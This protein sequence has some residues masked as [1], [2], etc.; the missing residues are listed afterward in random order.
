M[1]D[2]TPRKDAV[3]S[4]E[5]SQRVVDR[6]DLRGSSLNQLSPE[7]HDL[8]ASYLGRQGQGG[9]ILNPAGEAV[10]LTSKQSSVLERELKT[11]HRAAQYANQA[12]N[13]DVADELIGKIAALSGAVERMLGTPTMVDLRNA[14]LADPAAPGSRLHLARLGSYS[15]IM[16]DKA[17]RDTLINMGAGYSHTSAE[18]QLLGEL[19]VARGLKATGADLTDAQR[20]R[21]IGAREDTQKRIEE[22]AKRYENEKDGFKKIEISNEMAAQSVIFSQ[23]NKIIGE[24]TKE[25]KT[26]LEKMVGFTT[27]LAGI[28]SLSSMASRV[29]LQ[30]P[31]TYGTAPALGALGQQGEIASVVSQGLMAVEQY[32]LARSQEVFGIGASAMGVG[33]SMMLNRGLG[34]G[35][36]GFGGALGVAGGLVASSGL[37]LLGMGDWGVDFMKATGMAKSDDEIFGVTLAQQLL[38][39]QRLMSNF[40]GGRTGMLAVGGN[41]LGYYFNED[42]TRKMAEGDLIGEDGSIQRVVTGNR[43]LDEIFNN[44]LSLLSLVDPDTMSQTISSAA[45]SLTGSSGIGLTDAAVLAERTGGAFGIGSDAA[46]GMLEMLQSAGVNDPTRSLHMAIGGGADA[47]GNINTFTVGNITQSIIAATQSLK[48]QNIAR[49][50]DEL[51]KEVTGFRQQIVRGGSPLG[52]MLETNP[53]LFNKVMQDV[54]SSVKQSLHDPG[55]LALDLSLGSSLKDVVEGRTDVL[56]RRIQFFSDSPMLEGIDFSDMDEVFGNQHAV[57][58]LLRMRELTGIQDLQVLGSLVQTV[59]DPSSQMTP[60][61][62][63]ALVQGGE[64]A[65]DDRVLEIYEST[66]G[67]TEALLN[68]QVTALTASMQGVMQ[69]NI[70]LNEMVM[71]YISNSDLITASSAAIDKIMG[72]LEGIMKTGGEGGD[73]DPGLKYDPDM[74][75]HYRED[76]SG[77][78][79]YLPKTHEEREETGETVLDDWLMSQPIGIPDRFGMPDYGNEEEEDVSPGT[80]GQ[81]GRTAPRI[82]EV[83]TDSSANSV[84]LSMRIYG[85]T[86]TELEEHVVRLMDNRYGPVINEVA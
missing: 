13:R 65:V 25:T 43:V 83:Q 60:E 49:N 1:P 2:N 29:F 44:D 50:S 46:L 42:V 47:E 21:F 22:L 17:H 37:G 58:S 11:M 85:M 48:L 61:E 76:S 33:T 52:D 5:E 8:I 53:Q 40:A 31:F 73:D 4:F 64:A 12:G 72:V 67:S 77:A 24:S 80:T 82:G 19:K 71:Q 81:T 35:M 38:N 34:A 6:L 70:A 75:R 39:P 28:L 69:T 15:S 41:D 27:R 78:R 55:M 79:L 86:T 32:N 23:L 10:Y 14:A 9:D 84:V 20:E 54:Q 63:E 51:M 36:R 62:I 74:G 57:F 56:M 68:A 3:R 18:K 7:D 30:D 16:Y 45:M 26:G 59:K 66:L